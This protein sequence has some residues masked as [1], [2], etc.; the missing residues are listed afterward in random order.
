ML[1]AMPGLPMPPRAMALPLPAPMPTARQ[2]RRPA[3]GLAELAAAG[4]RAPAR[5]VPPRAE[6]PQP[7]RRSVA[8]C[9]LTPLNAVR[10]A[11][12]PDDKRRRAVDLALAR[13]RSA[14]R[15]V[16]CAVDCRARTDC[17]THATT[18]AT[19]RPRDDRR[20]TD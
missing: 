2:R 16:R 14:R 5:P 19:E 6:L 8:A 1:P 20:P 17:R 7:P 3:T 15:S 18:A 11:F 4:R 13:P 12:E 10:H 9:E